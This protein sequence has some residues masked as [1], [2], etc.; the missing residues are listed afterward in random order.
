MKTSF[1]ILLLGLLFYGCATKPT[2]DLIQPG[3][4]VR[5]KGYG[6]SYIIHVTTREGSSIQGIRLV[7]IMAD[8]EEITHTADT[9]TVSEGSDQNSVTITLVNAKFQGKDMHGT[10]HI[11]GPL[12][13]TR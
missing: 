3:K 4:D 1:T 13:L 5:L 11:L 7:Q 10:Y 9:G 2:I 12:I 8:G 6:R